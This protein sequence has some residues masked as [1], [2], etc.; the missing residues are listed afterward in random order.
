MRRILVSVLAIWIG[1]GLAMSVYY[2]F[3][4]GADCIK[5]E[6]LLKGFFWC[7][8]KSITPAA[9]TA[10]QTNF[11]LRGL[12]WPYFLFRDSEIA[13]E[14]AS[15]RW[16][17]MENSTPYTVATAI[18]ISNE[19]NLKAVLLVF[20]N[21]RNSCVPELSFLA[22]ANNRL[23]DPEGQVRIPTDMRIAIDRETSRSYKAVFNR[24]T[25][26]I[27]YAMRL[28]EELL[29]EM[30]KS[31]SILISPSNTTKNWTFSLSDFQAVSASQYASCKASR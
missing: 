12:A 14:G 28:D 11:L 9:H 13:N 27:E 15:G 4:L 7:S 18:P 24:Y 5:D 16:S 31:R 22:M 20:F 21:P 23:G 3:K 29:A 17:V 6:G 25:S 1:V 2:E 10:A 30:R 19:D 8:K 26:G